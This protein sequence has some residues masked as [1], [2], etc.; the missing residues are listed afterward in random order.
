[1]SSP[2]ADE[3][4][5][6]LIPEQDVAGLDVHGR[7][8]AAVLVPIYRDAG[9]ELVTVFTRRRDDLRRHAGE[10][11]FPGG[12]QDIEARGLLGVEER[13]A[14]ALRDLSARA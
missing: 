9:G 14:E 6:M 1:M 8:D 2:L 5:P 12:R 11:S 13:L 10:I 7:V 3:L 4:R